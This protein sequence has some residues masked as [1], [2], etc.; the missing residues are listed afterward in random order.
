M[1]KSNLRLYIREILKEQTEKLPQSAGIVIVKYIDGKPLYLGLKIYGRYDI[2]KGK[3]DPGEDHVK[4]AKRETLEEAGI[5]SSA[6]KFKW[7]MQHY[8]S[9][10][11]R[12][13]VAEISPEVEVIISPNPKTGVW[14]H[15][16]FNWLT[17]DDIISKAHKTIKNNLLW[18]QS[19]IEK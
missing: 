7:G 17:F 6:L 15:H 14:E 4:A 5:E 16:G 12:S 10:K 19:V 9:K 1:K 3:V 2:P 13:Y 11:V 8:D 18:A